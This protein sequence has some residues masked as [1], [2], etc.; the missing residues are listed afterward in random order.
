MAEKI[1]TGS[2][3][4]AQLGNIGQKSYGFIGIETEDKTH[5]KVK[6]AAFTEYE[7]LEPGRRVHVVAENL[8]NMDVLTAKL[9]SLAE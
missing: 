2:I 9:I 4:S 8:G 6:V 1:F 3:T 7:T 5:L